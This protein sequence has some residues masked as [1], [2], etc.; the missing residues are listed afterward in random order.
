MSET[1]EIPGYGPV[2]VRPLSE[3]QLRRMEDEAPSA[4]A[5]DAIERLIQA[6]A[7]A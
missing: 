6:R 5:A 3:G 7:A 4:G 1:V 2:E